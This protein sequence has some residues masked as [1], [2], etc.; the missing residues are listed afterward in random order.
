MTGSIAS[1]GVDH[2]GNEIETQITVGSESTL[3]G[4]GEIAGTTRLEEGGR[5]RPTQGT[6]GR[7]TLQ[8]LE[9]ETGTLGSFIEVS[10]HAAGSTGVTV[11]EQL[12]FSGSARPTF[13]IRF[14][15]PAPSLSV[16]ET[17][18]LLDWGATPAAIDDP[19]GFFAWSTD[20]EGIDGFFTL[21]S[22]SNQLAFTIAAIPEPSTVLLLGAALG[23]LGFRM[24]RGRRERDRATG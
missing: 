1:S 24:L 4:E 22:E 14:D 8:T 15:L 21:D 6:D 20:R 11:M 3:E 18:L 16:G 17:F 2:E 13:D 12:T 5:L 23:W 19:N 10:I 9:W 7:L